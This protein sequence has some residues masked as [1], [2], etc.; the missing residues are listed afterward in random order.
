MSESLKPRLWYQLVT[1]QNLRLK[2]SFNKTSLKEKSSIQNII[3]VIVSKT[4][5]R[6]QSKTF[7]GCLDY[8]VCHA[9]IPSSSLRYRKYLKPKLKIIS[10]KL[11]EFPTLPHT[12]HNHILHILGPWPSSDLAMSRVSLILGPRP[13]SS[14]ARITNL[15]FS[16]LAC[17]WASP[18]VHIQNIT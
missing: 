12:I 1:S 18:T 10:T 5:V 2:I 14:P 13:T 16:S 6:Y 8:G 7:P 17:H 15:L 9:I 4:H 11:S 3:R